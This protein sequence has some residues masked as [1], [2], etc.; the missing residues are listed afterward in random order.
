MKSIVHSPTNSQHSIPSSIPRKDT[1]VARKGKKKN[2]GGR[3]LYNPPSVRDTRGF[4]R[5]PTHG[6]LDWV[7]SLFMVS[8]SNQAAV[9][10][11][12]LGGGG[13]VHEL[14][15][16]CPLVA[17]SIGSTYLLHVKHTTAGDR[18]IWIPRGVGLDKRNRRKG[19]ERGGHQQIPQVPYISGRN[20]LKRTSHVD[21]LPQRKGWTPV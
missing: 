3:N 1:N 16:I 21:G 10:L 19:V 8:E 14:R 6:G 13:I 18:K 4:W 15:K 20:F 2:G 9:S 12:C 7:K 17:S 11:G 5:I